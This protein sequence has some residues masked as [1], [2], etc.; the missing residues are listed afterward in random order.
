MQPSNDGTVQGVFRLTH[1]PVMQLL[2]D[3]SSGAPCWAAVDLSSNWSTAT[4][5][6]TVFWLPESGIEAVIFASGVSAAAL[7]WTHT[8]SG[9]PDESRVTEAALHTGLITVG[10]IKF[11]GWRT[12]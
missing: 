6:T 12:G 11:T 1:P 4:E 2:A 9:T 10:G 3:H 7:M 8:A 5:L